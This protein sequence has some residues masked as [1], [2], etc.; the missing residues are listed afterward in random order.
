[1][2]LIAL[3]AGPNAAHIPSCSSTSTDVSRDVETA[4]ENGSSIGRIIFSEGGETFT[5]M[6]HVGEDTNSRRVPTT[7]RIRLLIYSPTNMTH[8]VH[9]MPT[10]LEPSSLGTKE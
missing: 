2:T 9:S 8:N 6:S 10:H 5:P 1:M 4:H 3:R 7:K